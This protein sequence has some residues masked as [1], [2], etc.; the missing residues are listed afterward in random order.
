[1]HTGYCLVGQDFDGGERSLI[2]NLNVLTR[3]GHVSD[4]YPAADCVRPADD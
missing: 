2:L 4:A 1:M 3:A